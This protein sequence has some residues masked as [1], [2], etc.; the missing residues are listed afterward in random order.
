M[1][2][3][4]R[5]SY[6]FLRGYGL[7]KDFMARAKEVGGTVVAADYCST[8]GHVAWAE[9]GCSA[10]GVTLP[11]VSTLEKDP[12]HG[13]VTLIARTADELT[14]LYRLVSLAND[15]FYYR[16]RIKW[17]QIQGVY[18]LLDDALP[19]DME[20]ALRACDAVMLKP[21]THWL[22]ERYNS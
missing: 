8:W 19:D 3:I 9:A 15:Q 1:L 21:R 2:H 13:L 17:D 10:L 6:S 22:H 4:V 5:S 14:Q 16:P 12:R 11:A 7:P 20:A 18:A